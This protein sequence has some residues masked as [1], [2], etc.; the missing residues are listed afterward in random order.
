MT[1]IKFD[2]KGMAHCTRHGLVQD[3]VLIAK[4][5]RAAM[6]EMV[7]IIPGRRVVRL[8]TIHVIKPERKAKRCSR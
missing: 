5:T 1:P 4:G 7:A 3:N 8:L 6:R 2:S